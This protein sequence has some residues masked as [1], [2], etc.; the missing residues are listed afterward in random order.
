MLIAACT[1]PLA[2]DSAA[3]GDSSPGGLLSVSINGGGASARTLLPTAPVFTKYALEFTG[4]DGQDPKANEEDITN[5]FLDGIALEAGDWTIKA[6]GYAKFKGADIAVAEGSAT[7]TVVDG[8]PAKVD[9]AISSIT[10]GSNGDFTY[11]IVVPQG[12]KA[13]S[14]AI[15]LKPYTVDTGDAGTAI[16]DAALGDFTVDASSADWTYSGTVSC[17]PGYY[18]LTVALTGDCTAAMRTELVRIYPNMETTGTFSFSDSD[19]VPVIT[20]SGT[21]DFKINGVAQTGVSVGAFTDPEHPYETAIGTASTGTGVTWTMDIQAL[22]APTTVYFSLV[23]LDGSSYVFRYCAQTIT[24][25]DQ[26]ISGI[27]LAE[28]A[29]RVTLS[30]TFAL[31]KDGIAQAPETMTIFVSTGS[32]NSSTSGSFV[33]DSSGAWTLNLDAVDQDTP[34]YFRV[35]SPNHGSQVYLTSSVTYKDVDVANIALELKL[36]TLSGSVSMMVN[37]VTKSNVGWN[38]SLQSTAVYGQNTKNYGHDTSAADGTW[39][40]VTG[41]L[42]A[43]ETVFM[44]LSNTI[45]GTS[46]NEVIPYTVPAGDAAITGIGLDIVKNNVALSGTL[47]AGSS[48]VAIDPA[49]W[50]VFATTED[51]STVTDAYNALLTGIGGCPIV[52][53]DGSFTWNMPVEI[54]A[55]GSRDVWIWACRALGEM[56]AEAY[57]IKV[58][59]SLAQVAV[60]GQALVLSDM[61]K[62]GSTIGGSVFVGASGIDL[63][64]CALYALSAPVLSQ[65]AVL[66]LATIDAAG[67][68][69]MTFPPSATAQNVYFVLSDMNERIYYMMTYPVHISPGD[70]SGI[71][72]LLSDMEVMSAP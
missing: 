26:D 16:V 44:H 20:L 70:H 25:S 49:S 62:F 14:C 53:A 11:S 48:G 68:W 54:L 5:A 50:Y 35:N 30:G 69:S 40:I 38:I 42:V 7:V 61:N 37:S 29:S 2:T 3:G 34:V 13:S 72:L 64:S 46:Y 12:L 18:L 17:A 27:A 65:E 43:G 55:T 33:S 23:K 58:P 63:S 67:S 56:V 45:D 66:G 8:V 21:V 1:N 57:S 24:V 59:I 51:P 6:I 41:G 36:R 32:E 60:S 71:N 19:F 28:D 9:I 47:T 10:S 31:S 4:L 22:K 15:S 39:S 52:A